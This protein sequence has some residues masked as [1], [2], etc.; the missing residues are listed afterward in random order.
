MVHSI[1]DKK[2]ELADLQHLLQREVTLELA[3]SAKEKIN[4]CRTYLDNKV[5]SA[6]KPIY[7]INT[8]FG[9]LYGKKYFQR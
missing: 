2:I 7:G 4:A 5:K 8:G 3:T 9:S 1:S 6:G